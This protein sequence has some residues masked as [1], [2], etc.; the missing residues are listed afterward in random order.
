MTITE[1]FTDA[2]KWARGVSARNA[3]GGDVRGPSPDAVAWSL[4]GAI[5]RCYPWDRKRGSEQAMRV[6]AI[7]KAEVGSPRAWNDAEGRTFEDVQALV[8]RL[9]V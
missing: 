6:T 7:I 5:E 1:L 2:S 9:G 3:A 4:V 8:R